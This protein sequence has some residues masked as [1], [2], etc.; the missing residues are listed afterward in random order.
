MK[1]TIFYGPVFIVPL[2]VIVL[3]NERSP[4]TCKVLFKV[5]GAPALTVTLPVAVVEPENVFIPVPENN[6]LP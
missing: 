6:K 3:N 4:F 5:T 1:T 2:F